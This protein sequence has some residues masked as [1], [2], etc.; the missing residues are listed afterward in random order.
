MKRTEKAQ[1]VDSLA[2]GFI[3]SKAAFVIGYKGLTVAQMQTLR[4][5]LRGKQG[6]LKVAKGRLMKRSLPTAQADD[7]RPYLKDQIAL[8]FVKDEAAPVAKILFEFSKNNQALKLLAGLT[9]GSVVNEQ[10]VVEIAS[11]PSRT[12]LLARLC[13]VL[14]ASLVKLMLTVQAIADQKERA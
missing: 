2:Q 13:G 3:E 9:E 5:Q 6:T 10:G 7:L 8:V 12:E 1:V 11:L 4:S 14:N